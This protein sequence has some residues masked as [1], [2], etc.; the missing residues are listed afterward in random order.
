[1]MGDGM[2]EFKNLSLKIG[3]NNI[4]NHLCGE[5]PKGKITV[6][7]GANGAGKSSLLKC[8]ASIIKPNVGEIYIDKKT[9]FEIKPNERARKI[10]FLEQNGDIH[11]DVNVSTLV[12]MGCLV[13]DNHTQSNSEAIYDALTITDTLHLKDKVAS[14]LSGGEKSRVLLARVL[15]GKPEYILADEPLAALDPAHQLDTLA[16][17]RD[18]AAR[19]VGIAIVLHDLT[20]AARIADE[21]IMMKNGVIIQKGKANDVLTPQIIEETYGVKVKITESDN[22]F[23]II[24]PFSRI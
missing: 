22:G 14:K 17:F 7:L 19:G 8:I 13:N 4:L 23:K 15:A 2:I 18:I 1:M 12:E 5:I 10:G 9:L 21:I 24:S 6:I 11:W 16:N 3:E 20:Y